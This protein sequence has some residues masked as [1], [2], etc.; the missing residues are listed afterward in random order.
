M[1]KKLNSRAREI[2]NAQYAP[3]EI[4][5]AVFGDAVVDA[6]HDEDQ[7]LLEFGRAFDVE[8]GEVVVGDG[9][10]CVLRPALKP[11]HRAAGYQSGEL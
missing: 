8:L 1:D 2:K 6:A 5:D 9:D 11:V 3:L 7:L 10:Q 4:V